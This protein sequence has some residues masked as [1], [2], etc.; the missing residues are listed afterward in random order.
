VHA[1]EFYLLMRRQC[2]IL[3]TRA[4]RDGHLLRWRTRGKKTSPGRVPPSHSTFSAVLLIYQAIQ[5]SE[6][7]S[8]DLNSLTSTRESSE[9]YRHKL[10]TEDSADVDNDSF[11]ST[12]SGIPLDSALCAFVACTRTSRDKVTAE[13]PCSFTAIKTATG[14]INPY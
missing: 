14:L 13:E 12:R 1:R 9:K 5:R 3:P 2:I 8:R 11:S 7:I 4:G 6:V 10:E